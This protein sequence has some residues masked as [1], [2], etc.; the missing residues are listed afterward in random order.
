MRLISIGDNVVD[1]Y[2]DLGLMFPGGN[3][4][5]VAV[6]SKRLGAKHC[7]YI[8]LVGN[9]DAGDHVLA[10][11]RLENVDITRI[12]R[13]FGEN[14]EAVV[15]LNEDGDRVFVASN[16]GG[17]QTLITLRLTKDDIAYIDTHDIVHTSVYSY[18]EN[19]L[20]KIKRPISFDFSDHRED[21]YLQKVCPYLTY[22]FFSGSH[23]SPEDCEQLIDK[24]HGYGVKVVG[25]T[26][27]SHGA[28]LSMEGQRYQQGISEASQVV[29]TLGA[30]DAF[31]AG[32]L[33]HYHCHR[34]IPE[35]LERAA[36][37][38]AL[39]CS[40]YGAF[41]YGTPRYPQCTDDLPK[42]E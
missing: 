25:V 26:R 18:I 14:G 21:E 39:T 29:D 7:S 37:A 28:L 34:K 8:G 3:A 11:L 38:A 16:G 19:E 17:V 33:T 22:A 31:I 20:L 9:D 12:R 1:Y 35:A 30:G 4:V 5:N 2:K 27:G 6:L 23:L 40:Y 32:F 41:G 36:Q 10:S 15:A 13:A 42:E 24:V